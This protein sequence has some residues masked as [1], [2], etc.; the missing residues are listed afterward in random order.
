MPTVL[1]RIIG[2]ILFILIGIIG[3]ILIFLQLEKKHRYRQSK[4]I[5]FLQVRIQKKTA[6]KS[7]DIEATDHIQQMK[8]NIEIMNQ[9]YKNFY[10][11]YRHLRSLFEADFSKSFF[12]DLKYRLFG[13][14]YISMELFV[15]KEQIK[16][17]V[18]VPETQLSTVRKMIAAFYPESFI[19]D[20]DQPKL[21]EA[22]KYMAG[23]EFNF[24]EH[25]VHPI[26]TYEAFEADPMDSILSSY[27]NV[28]KDEKMV[29]QI[30]VEPLPSKRLKR[31]RKKADKIKQGKDF[32]FFK[33]TFLKLRK[34]FSNEDTKHE[35]NQEEK[36]KHNFSQQQ[37]GDFDKKT[38]DEIFRTKI[39]TF[40]TSIEKN[41]PAKMI[42][43]MERL[44]NQYNYIG[45]NRLKFWKIKNLKSFAEDFVLRNFYTNSS[46]YY[47]L[48]SFFKPNILNI[49]ELSS[50]V[51]F[52][53]ARFNL[54]PRIAWQ[55]A[56]IVPAPE[57]MPSNGMHLGRNEYGGVKRDV[58]LSDKDRFRHVYIVGQTGT[59][60]STMILTQA[61]EDMRRGNGFCVIDPHGDLVDT[62]MK[63]FPKE[64]IDDLIYFDLSN[65]EYPIA[66]NP[67][68]GAHTEDERD[69]LTNDMVEMFVDMYGHE[70]FGPR[71]QDYFRHAC[72]LL[73]EQPEGGTL[74]DIM[75]LF[76]DDAYAESK[77]RN[78][79]NP[80]IAAWW[81]KTYKKMGDREKAEIIPFIQAK[82]GPFTTGTYIRNVIGQPK[83]SFNFSDA[84]Q[85]GKVIMCKL[86]KGLTGEINSQLIGRMVAMQIKL[87]ALKRAS[88]PEEDRHPFFLYVDEFQN[89]VSRSFESILSEARKYRLGLTMAHQYIDQLKKEGLGGSLDLSK[90]IFGN[91]GTIFALKVGALDAEPLEQEFSPEFTKMDLQSSEMFKGII[92]MSINGTQSRPFSITTRTIYGDP[93]LNTPE[94]IEIMKQISSL[95]RGTKRE[96]VDKEIYFRVGV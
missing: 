44:F 75:R 23:G 68:D 3:Y 63:H 22:G 10:S 88:M 91:V 13:G 46:F 65:T 83:S 18:G 57:D 32:G 9:V 69:V 45:L 20:I 85:E 71:I 30:L 34:G 96:L 29:L 14:D 37:L 93:P 59:G 53:H 72:F 95:K 36:S 60:K 7:T 25:S 64:R 24:T 54:N 61:K 19:E 87:S 2:I 35:K 43:E 17:I 28:G 80:V 16:Y 50:I 47:Q 74:I 70:I 73:M 58:I 89:Y 62:L 49:K 27:N 33:K 77:I 55:K 8:N 56:K 76:T 26:K 39:R 67:L 81:N 48:R 38:D 11:V 66:F 51:H 84:M 86:A 6:A 1:A 40:A 42:D 12:G 31:M 92:K 79:K 94:K 82:F 41:R 78:V 90:T 52:P 5:R 15:E 4:H 21:L